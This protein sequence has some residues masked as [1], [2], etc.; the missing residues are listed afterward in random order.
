MLK[1]LD[2]TRTVRTVRPN[3]LL[4]KVPNTRKS[5]ATDAEGMAINKGDNMK[6]VGNAVRLDVLSKASRVTSG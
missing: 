1:I 2:Q 6:E 3:Q 5:V 4:G